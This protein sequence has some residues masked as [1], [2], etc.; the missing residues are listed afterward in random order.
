MASTYATFTPG[1]STNNNKFTMSVWVKRTKITGDY[2]GIYTSRISGGAGA[3]LGLFIG[4]DNSV[5]YNSGTSSSTFENTNTSRKVRDLNGWY[6]IVVAGDT[7]QSGTDKLKIWINNEQQTS[8]VNDNRSSF[9]GLSYDL[10]SS[11]YANQLGR[12]H[13]NTYY[14]DGVLS[15]FHF[16]D[17][18]TY[19]PSTF[20][21]TDSTTGE[22]QINTN[23]SVTYGNN[24]F[25]LFKDDNSLNDDSGEGNN[26][27]L[28]GGTLTKTED[29]PSNVFATLNPLN[30]PS[31]ATLSN[32][33]NYVQTSGSSRDTLFSTIGVSS[34]KYYAEFKLVAGESNS[35][36]MDFGINGD[37]AEIVRSV[38]PI[39]N[40]A[41]GYSFD[42][43]SAV[44]VT[45]GSSA[46][47]FG[48][49]FSIGDIGM[50]AVDFDNLKIYF[51]KN[52]TWFNSGDPTSGSTGTG[53][54]FN[55]TAPSST[56]SGF[57]HFGV[58]D[59][60][61]GYNQ[62]FASNFGNGYF[63]TTAVASAGTNA[64]G[65]GIFEYDVPT[66]YTA[67]STKGLNE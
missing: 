30:K 20:G 62:T 19:T 41:T 11:T 56:P 22:W 5:W 32:G 42:T 17:G 7:T 37:P 3:G 12:K 31:S 29:C 1:T 58:S 6:H 14:L 57:Y 35:V 34:G 18:T 46:G 65:I 27:T 51:G 39:G 4:N 54:A 64:S 52:G 8:F 53:S 43:E 24:G 50:L 25:F 48:S 49:T 28:G 45:N 44:K 26:F 63:G 38:V 23:P 21:S 9:A 47:S 13:D 59:H 16:I 2:Q 66:G 33:N 10:G 60:S 67:L 61:T 15:H 36:R 55:I 40:G